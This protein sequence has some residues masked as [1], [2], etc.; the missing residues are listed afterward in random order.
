MGGVVKVVG[1]GQALHVS[2]R[3]YRVGRRSGSIVRE[4]SIE[5]K[6]D[7]KCYRYFWSDSSQVPLFTLVLVPRSKAFGFD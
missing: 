4:P 3:L 2:A 6:V 1:P 5:L 7:E